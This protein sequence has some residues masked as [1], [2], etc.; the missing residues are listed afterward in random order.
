MEIFKALIKLKEHQHIHK[1]KEPTTKFL[2]DAFDLAF[3]A[4]EK[5]IPMEPGKRDSGA[6]CCK[7]CD[8]ILA[9]YHQ[10]YC[11]TCGQAQDWS[12]DEK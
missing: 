11:K 12:K 1:L 5:Q 4:M 10:N 9:S 6:P 3:A 7:S 2:N 8:N